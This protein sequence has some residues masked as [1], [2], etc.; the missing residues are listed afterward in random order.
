[1]EHE[2][3]DRRREE[4]VRGEQGAAR[5]APP[6][7][8]GRHDAIEKP[9]FCMSATVASC[10][11]RSASENGVPSCSALSKASLKALY[12]TPTLGPKVKPRAPA[13]NSAARCQK[14]GWSL[15]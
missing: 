6:P 7:P 5:R 8:L 15:K 10:M 9:D 11:V 4:Q 3:H 12:A 14:S 13:E 2:Q 1:E